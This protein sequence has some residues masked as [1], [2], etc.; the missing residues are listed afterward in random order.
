MY[1][2][3]RSLVGCGFWR[4][5]AQEVCFVRSNS[6]N[7]RR[8]AA[9]SSTAFTRRTEVADYMKSCPQSRTGA[10]RAELRRRSVSHV[11]SGAVQLSQLAL[12]SL[13][14]LAA[15]APAPA[16]AQ[17]RFSCS[18]AAG[19]LDQSICDALTPASSSSGGGGAND[20]ATSTGLTWKSEAPVPIGS[21]CTRDPIDQQRAYCGW[22]GAQCDADDMCD[23]GHCVGGQ[24]SGVS[25]VA[26]VIRGCHIC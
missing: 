5:R 14:L 12:A 21:F 3:E 20:S 10:S 26:P 9:G 22:I 4:A 23:A 7:D 15:I 13:V 6:C 24:C 1:E 25:D 17:G 11:Q 19:Q 2:P 8:R 16:N 18:N